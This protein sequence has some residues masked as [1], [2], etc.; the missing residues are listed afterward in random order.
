MKILILGAMDEEIKFL[1]K[2]ISEINV[3]KWNSY[4]I[5]E[6]KLYGKDVV[7]TKSGD[8]KVNSAIIT[9]HLIDLYDVSCVLFTGVAG[10]LGKD[11]HV[12]DVVVAEK[13][14]HHDYDVTS[15]GYKKCQIPGFDVF[16]NSDENLV[17]IA[18]NTKLDKYFVKK[19]IIATG[20]Q[21]VDSNHK[22]K[23]DNFYGASCVDMEG[24]S[25]AQT[26]FINGIPFLIIRVMSDNADE[27]SPGDFRKNMP[28][29]ANN[30]QKIIKN[31]I[32]NM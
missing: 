2:D 19:G 7:L 3:K 15:L 1:M 12:G 13:L 22:I 16:F 29:F 14:F 23:K 11:L 6:G 20:E 25:V 24:C 31:I 30:S 18:L 21:F 27:S 8:G 32:E 9:Q 17:K 5:V 26:C 4:D 28:I 10:A